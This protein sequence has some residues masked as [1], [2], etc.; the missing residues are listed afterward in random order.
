MN[1]SALPSM[2][3]NCLFE[4][5]ENHPGKQAELSA[6]ADYHPAMMLLGCFALA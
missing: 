5:N 4:L 2:M 3:S 1:S 6:S